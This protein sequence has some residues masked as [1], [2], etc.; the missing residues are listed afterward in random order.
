MTGAAALAA[1]AAFRADA[2]YVTICAP[3]DSVP[4]LEE[5]V[6]EAVSGRC[7]RWMKRRRARTRSRSDPG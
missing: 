1:R 6:V 4:A 7:S 3:E 5:L 2:G